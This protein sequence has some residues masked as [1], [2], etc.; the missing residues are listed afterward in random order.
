[1]KVEKI[2][3]ENCFN[4]T[5]TPRLRE[6]FKPTDG[7]VYDPT[8]FEPVVY[9]CPECKSEIEFS[10]KDFEKHKRSSFSNLQESEIALINE[11]LERNKLNAESFLD[12]YCPG[13]RKATRIYFSTG[14]TGNHGGD[15]AVTI[16]FALFLK[17]EG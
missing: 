8:L 1:M 6:R 16:N 14:Y 13:C 2:D 4:I 10:D 17:N 9:R 7:V 5:H 15:F 3:I 12:F 11:F